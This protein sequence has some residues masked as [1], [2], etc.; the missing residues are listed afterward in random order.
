ME[1]IA[2]VVGM[3]G[4]LALVAVANAIDR[5]ADAINRRNQNELAYFRVWKDREERRDP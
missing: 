1:F 4:V 2:W 3:A 5:V